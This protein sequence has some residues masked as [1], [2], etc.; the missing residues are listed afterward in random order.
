MWLVEVAALEDDKFLVQTV[1]DVLGVRDHSGRPPMVVLTEFLEDK[2]L[3]LVLD[4]CEHLVD[5]CAMLVSDMLRAAPGLR[6]LATSRQV[7]RSGGE[8]L[9]EVPPLP[10]P[11]AERPVTAQLVAR[12]AAVRLFAERAAVARPGFRVDAGNR[13]AVVRVCRRL[14]GIPLAIE[15]TAV[16]V[17]ALSLDQILERLESCYFELLAEGSRAAVPRVRTLRAAIA[18]S[19][20][21]CSEQERTVWLRASVF[22]GAFDLGAAEEVCAD[23]GIAGE[24]VLELVAGLVDK[25]VL[26]RTD[27]SVARFRMLEAIRQFGEQGL[28]SSGRQSV[29]RLRHRDYYAR[30][31]EV[32][33]R[34][35]V[36]PNELVWFAW[37]RRERA[38]L[39]TALEFCLTEL[40]QARAGLAIAASLWSY[41]CISGWFSEARHW[42][43]SAL[44]LERE[45][46]PARAKALWVNGLFA[47]MQGDSAAGW[48]M[49]RECQALARRLGDEHSF[50]YAKRLSGTAAFVRLDFPRSLALFED[51]LTGLADRAA[52]WIILLQMSA[53]PSIAGE[54][55]AA[56]F[57]EQCLNLVNNRGG[58]M[59]KSWAL[60]VHGL[61]RW[62]AGHRQLADR[63]IREALRTGRPLDDQWG[64]A[65]CLE[66]LAW[67][68][69]A[70]RNAERAARLLGAASRLW[71]ATG[72]SPA[73]LPHIAPD[74]ALYGR[75]IQQAL[76]NEARTTHFSEGAK[77]TSEQAIAYALSH[78]A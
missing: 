70:E 66:I 38:N 14:E 56:A 9:L 1:A 54:D 2:E 47:F 58:P 11:Q 53:T 27:G 3:L 39:R 44:N 34:E 18:S 60:W 51:A 37:F 12:N 22:T 6:V 50:A 10:V 32:A 45:S 5:A 61:G 64:T 40:G 52:I 72:T 16:R 73:E 7:L 67:N 21:L 30:L 28:A 19:F 8:A 33:E 20:E 62:T 49:E 15:L 65:H 13:A 43:E 36:G 25:S 48:S 26:V 41:W 29:V 42:L 57:G 63:L 69:A 74:H 78:E 23:T 46:S 35:W 77:L 68:A 17:R 24:D 31:A 59:S 4:N 76:G 55:R 75:R 71:Q